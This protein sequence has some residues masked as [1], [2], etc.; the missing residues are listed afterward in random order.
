MKT[1]L[2]AALLLLASVCFFAFALNASHRDAAM[3]CWVLST[4][5]FIAAAMLLLG[6]ILGSSAVTSS[7]ARKKR[8]R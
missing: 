1:K 6:I 8:R 7:E 5:F 2:S 4:I 3:G